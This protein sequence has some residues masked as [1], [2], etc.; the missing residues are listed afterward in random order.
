MGPDVLSV[1]HW[2]TK[3]PATEQAHLRKECQPCAYFL[4]KVDGCRWG[5]DCTFCH[6][7]NRSDIKRRKAEK[8]RALRAAEAAEKAV[9]NEDQR[10]VSTR[11]ASN[12]VPDDALQDYKFCKSLQFQ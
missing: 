10:S 2:Q 5:K 8:K 3:H 12:E 7:C 11:T 4:Y 1:I 6:L 9:V